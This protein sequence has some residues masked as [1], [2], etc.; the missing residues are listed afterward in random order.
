[1]NLRQDLSPQEREKAERIGRL[2]FKSARP[3]WTL[4]SQSS[5]PAESSIEGRAG[6]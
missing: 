6:A 5:S 3:A 1:M 2:E 4:V